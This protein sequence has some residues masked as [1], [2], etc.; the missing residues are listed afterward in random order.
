[1]AAIFPPLFP[2]P[3]PGMRECY[4][5][6]SSS[7][8]SLLRS[9]S[10]YQA[11]PMEIICPITLVDH[12][13]PLTSTS[14]DN[15]NDNDNNNNREE[16]QER[17][18]VR[19]SF[20]SYK[21]YLLRDYEK[22]KK[23][24]D[25]NTTTTMTTNTS[26]ITPPNPHHD[27][28]H[29][30]SHLSPCQSS[31]PPSYMTI[32]SLLSDTT[33]S[34]SMVD[35]PSPS[36]SLPKSPNLRGSST[37]I[38]SK[39][40]TKRSFRTSCGITSLPS[41]NNN[42]NS[43]NS[44]NSNNPVD[45]A[46]GLSEDNS[47][48]T[49]QSDVLLPLPI[50]LPP[51]SSSSKREFVT[52]AEDDDDDS[53]SPVA[54]R[55]IT[56]QGSTDLSIPLKTARMTS[57]LSRYDDPS[58]YPSILPEETTVMTITRSESPPLPPLIS[59]VEL[60]QVPPPNPFHDILEVTF[61]GTGCATPSKYRNNSGILLHFLSNG[62]R[63]LK[64]NGSMNIISPNNKSN[65]SSSTTSST[66]NLV[67]NVQNELLGNDQL[68]LLQELNT[69]NNNRII[70]QDNRKTNRLTIDT[71]FHCYPQQPQQQQQQCSS[72][73]N[74]IDIDQSPQKDVDSK[75]SQ[76]NLDNVIAVDE[77]LPPDCYVLLD[78]GESIVSQLFQSV[79]GLPNLLQHIYTAQLRQKHQNNTSTS[80]T[81]NSNVDHNESS[82]A[83]SSSSAGHPT[84]NEDRCED[85]IKKKH[86]TLLEAIDIANRMQAKH[87]ILTHF[88]QRYPLSDGHGHGSWINNHHVTLAYDFMHFSFPSQALVLPKVSRDIATI[89]KLYEDS[90]Y[91]NSGEQDENEEV[92]QLATRSNE[93]L[94]VASNDS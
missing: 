79:Q 6:P 48:A 25:Q 24:V 41:F 33:N 66:S 35:S 90:G 67:S 46:R 29:R 16:Q 18:C 83:S 47:V 82:S 5:S 43:S 1:M 28:H 76:V 80:T 23:V 59:Q 14:N 65:K 13:Q 32:P 64:E 57:S 85:A 87:T 27:N 86:T 37:N 78:C 93:I 20:R 9:G 11:I 56:K 8:S 60:V 70:V 89:L 77:D 62:A 22:Y 68:T 72:D 21:D 94:S 44:S 10:L 55:M 4:H 36:P 75:S 45:L 31:A 92:E 88:S 2:K 34:S 38:F 30:P 26:S 15:N 71:N 61:L 3:L 49:M 39:L 58:C 19:I 54:M 91:D 17:D 73:G 40:N 51:P 52:E 50:P 42:N 84:F 7:S 81:G 74:E 63:G 53:T 69:T 12:D